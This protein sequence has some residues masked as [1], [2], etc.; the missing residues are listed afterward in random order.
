MAAGTRGDRR[1]YNIGTG[2][3][4]STRQLHSVIANAA[5]A[6]DDPEFYPPRLGDLRRSCLDISLAAEVLGWTAAGHDSTPASARTV[7]YF[8]SSIKDCELLTFC[9]S[10]AV[11]FYA[12]AP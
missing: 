6:P 8:R 4:T 11:V 3:E 10:L 7:D 1:R 2:T 5:G 12:T 9:C